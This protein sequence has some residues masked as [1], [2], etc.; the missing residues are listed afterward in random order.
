M[1]QDRQEWLNGI[2]AKLCEKMRAQCGRVGSSIP[3]IAEDGRYRED[4]AQ[5]NLYWW[6]NG[7]WG[8]ILWQ[9]YHA[10]QEESYRQAAEELENKL[11]KILA[12]SAGLDHD[13]GFLWLPTAVADYRLTGNQ[14]A[15][16]RGE[17]A[18][19]ILAGR[20]NPLGQ[21]IRAWNGADNSGW[22]IID[23]MMNLPLL[24]WMGEETGDPRYAA[25]AEMHADTAARLLVRADG[26]CNHIGILD[27][28]TGELLA[29]PGGQGAAEGSSW[30]RGQAWALYGYALSFRHTGKEKYL[31]IAKKVAHYFISNAALNGYLPLCDFRQPKE[32]VY[33]DAT[34]GACAV[35]G[36]LEIADHVPETQKDL[37]RESAWRM[38]EAMEGRFADWN[39]GTDSILQ[40]GK[41]AYHGNDG[42]QAI[43][44]GDYFFTE[45]ILRL[46]KKDV[47]IW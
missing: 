28:L 25:V 19:N 34:A 1:E 27:P 36:L 20:F 22:M 6:T 33:Y 18:A 42:Q 5:K 11:E 29:T 13:L 12:D 21:F 44:Y 14:K 23:C 41:V 40:Q 7:F 35:C 47:M 39:P 8:G 45:A 9:M 43:I 46:L 16:R 32:P 3:Y 4:M 31:D 17:L 2:Y 15:H 10:T 37:Y 24:Y 26:S 30:S 38:L